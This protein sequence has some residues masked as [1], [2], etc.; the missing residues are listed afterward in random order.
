MKT[1]EEYL[2]E[3]KVQ[4]DEWE[5]DLAQLRDKAQDASEDVKDK[6]EEQ[7]AEL[8]AKWDEGAAR[9]QEILD[10]A[11]DKWDALKDEAEE[12]WADIKTGA[13]DAIDR[14]KSMFS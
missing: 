6:V 10:A 13:K 9:R 14:V 8:K 11:D 12:Q 1:K 7:I 4:L 2:A 3:A 5:A